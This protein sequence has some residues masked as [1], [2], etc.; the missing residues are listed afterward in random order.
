MRSNRTSFITAVLLS[1]LLAVG[2][3]STAFAHRPTPS[4]TPSASPTGDNGTLNPDN[5]VVAENTTDGSSLFK[6]GFKVISVFGDV[7]DS[8]NAAV[9]T[10]S[11]VS[12]RTVAIAISIVLIVGEPSIVVPENLALAVNY[13]CTLCQTMALAYQLVLSPS[14]G[15]R[16]TRGSMKRMAAILAEI[17]TI[18]ASDLPLADIDAQV[19]ALVAELF[20]IVREAF[21]PRDRRD[22][23]GDHHEDSR[24]PSPS[25]TPTPT[26]SE[27]PT[28]SPTTTPTEEPSPSPSES[29]TPTPEPSPSS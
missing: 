25:S 26:P 16:L 9:A 1:A 10:S 23:K 14:D 5:I 2:G 12:C 20:D 29:T 24:S 13:D 4:P 6:F 15:P 7:V 28:P 21:A 27:S 22:E 8:G 18:G 19:S 17:Q 11:C 3:P